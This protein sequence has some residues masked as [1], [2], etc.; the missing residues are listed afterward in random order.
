MASDKIKR[1]K[2]R[3]FL[4]ILEI[5]INNLDLHLRANVPRLILTSILM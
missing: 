2:R 5:N 1:Q 4:P 3:R